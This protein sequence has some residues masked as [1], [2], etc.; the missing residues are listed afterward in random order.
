MAKAK[1]IKLLESFTGG[2]ENQTRL[3]PPKA[4]LSINY[5]YRKK[6]LILVEKQHPTRKRTKKQNYQRV[7][8]CDCDKLYKFLK[9]H[10]FYF[11][12][13]WYFERGESEKKG[14]TMNNVFMKYCLKFDISSLLRDKLGLEIGSIAV[15]DRVHYIRISTKL[16]QISQEEYLESFFEPI[17]P[18][19]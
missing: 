13:N 8:Y 14:L 5:L 6:H 4:N 10:L 15:E 9:N 1:V 19:R 2:L 16:Y 11:L 3:R 7:L 17:R 12:V 18:R